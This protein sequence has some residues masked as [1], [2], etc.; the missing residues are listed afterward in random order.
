MAFCEFETPSA[1]DEVY[2][3]ADGYELGGRWLQL[4]KLRPKSQ[5][6]SGSSGSAQKRH[7]PVSAA[8]RN[9][10]GAAGFEG[11]KMKFDD[12]DEY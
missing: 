2:N 7:A 9:R 3:Y 5:M 1:A 8:Q 10:G 6:N 12:D 11:K 4:D